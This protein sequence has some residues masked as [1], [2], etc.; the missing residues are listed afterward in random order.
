MRVG[1]R[2][3]WA[4]VALALTVADVEGSVR[5]RLQVAPNGRHLQFE[6]GTPFFYLGDTAWELFH[7]L[8]REDLVTFRP[9]G[10]GQSSLTVHDAPWLDFHMTQSSHGARSR[11]G[12][13]RRA[14]PRAYAPSPDTRRRAALRDDPRRVLPPRS[15][16]P[17]PL[18][19]RR[20][21]AGGVVVGH[22]RRVGG[23]KIRAARASDGAAGR[24]GCC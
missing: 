6:D 5:G 13:L 24:I 7:R 12:A 19:R 20:R 23:A 10:P 8:S 14:R 4:V 3:L 18:H 17:R 1:F 21:A 2:T 9:R 15:Q 11:H 16:S 22:G